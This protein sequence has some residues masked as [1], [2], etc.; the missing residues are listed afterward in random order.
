MKLKEI[1]NAS[2]LNAYFFCFKA[3]K[4]E[5][6]TQK[7]VKRRYLW[8]QS[9]SKEFLWPSAELNIEESVVRFFDLC[10][11]ETAKA[12][13]DHRSVVQDLGQGIGVSN[14]ILKQR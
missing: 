6:W 13:L 5:L 2:F 10:M 9:L 12:K 1:N 3:N 8:K 14:G 7:L 11:P 4:K